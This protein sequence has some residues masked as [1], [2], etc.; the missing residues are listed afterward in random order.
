MAGR[1]PI[2]AMCRA[3]DVSRSGY[4]AHAHKPSRPRR[5]EDE[6][7]KGRIRESLEWE[8]D[9][10]NAKGLEAE[11]LDA[12][13]RVVG[14]EIQQQLPA[15][16]SGSKLTVNGVTGFSIWYAGNSASV[17]VAVSSFSVE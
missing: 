3:L 6:R 2:G 5:V 11:P 12:A 13:F 16:R 9:V 15:T 4:Y 1:F 8:F 7:L 17:P 14:G 10:A